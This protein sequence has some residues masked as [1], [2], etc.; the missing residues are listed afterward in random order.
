MFCFGVGAI[1]SPLTIS[2]GVTVSE[3]RQHRG[4]EIREKKGEREEFCESIY[5]FMSSFLL[6]LL[7]CLNKF[8]LGFC[9]LRHDESCVDVRERSAWSPHTLDGYAKDSRP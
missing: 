1:G 8:K 9:K 7:F 2:R 5:F 3:W 6:L 4:K